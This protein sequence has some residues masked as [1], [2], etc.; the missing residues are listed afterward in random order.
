M[1][2]NEFI[3]L[4][5]GL[6]KI[7][8]VLSQDIKDFGLEVLIVKTI[9][10]LKRHIVKN[11][12]LYKSIPD[13][14]YLKDLEF[15]MKEVEV[16]CKKLEK[17][18]PVR[19]A[20]ND[21]TNEWLEIVSL[22]KTRFTGYDNN[23]S[24]YLTNLIIT[25]FYSHDSDEVTF[26]LELFGKHDD[27]S[28]KEYEFN[29]RN[30]CISTYDLS[31]AL[32]TELNPEYYKESLK[33]ELDYFREYQA[34]LET[35]YQG[36]LKKQ[37]YQEFEIYDWGAQFRKT[38]IKDMF[39]GFNDS[40]VRPDVIE[41][42]TQGKH[43]LQVDVKYLRYKDEKIEHQGAFYPPEISG[44]LVVYKIEVYVPWVDIET[45]ID[46]N[47]RN[48]VQEM[49]LTID[50]ELGHFIQEIGVVRFKNKRTDMSRKFGYPPRKTL[51]KVPGTK[52]QT[53]PEMINSISGGWAHPH[54]LRDTEF[55]TRLRDVKVK[56]ERLFIDPFNNRSN[57]DPFNENIGK[58][59]ILVGLDPRKYID[60]YYPSYQE[61]DYWLGY[62]KKNDPGK[63]NKA[64][65]E[66][67]KELK[68]YLV[69]PK[70]YQY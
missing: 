13:T 6:L 44:E 28:H 9:N 12:I 39:V 54:E 15:L 62:L 59:R 46:W 34:K 2:L 55:Y 56:I 27:E 23:K 70:N 65:K 36:L 21:Q 53:A 26:K 17:F 51:N 30:N 20:P 52:T 69:R 43:I 31:S 29:E 11:D 68:S 61:P 42:I 63:W 5:E 18:T 4:T 19:D 1:N 7:P 57:R 64:V 32:E 60:G 8:P 40:G 38:I 24:Y 58:F 66:L 14:F 22:P 25:K 48:A 16:A 3:F 49:D 67:Y 45:H 35:I 41:N 47:Y 10:Q 37:N 50:H 33:E